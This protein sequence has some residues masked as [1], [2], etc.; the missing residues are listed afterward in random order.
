MESELVFHHLSEVDSTNN[1]AV[2]KV[3]E[4][5]AKNGMAWFADNQMQG[6]GQRNKEWISAPGE[7]IILSIVL[8]NLAGF[9][10][11]P[12]VFNAFI[13]NLCR[14]FV[15]QQ[16]GENVLIKWPNDLYVH[17]K[18]T[19]G[20][21]IENIYRGSSWNWSI[22]GIGINVNQIHFSENLPNPTS[23][24]KITNFKYDALELS[25]M[26]H[27]YVFESFSSMSEIDSDAI[28][29][30]YNNNLYKKNQRVRFRKN[31]MVFEAMVQ[32]VNHFGELIVFDTIQKSYR[33]GEI[34]WLL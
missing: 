20:I 29:K 1:Y 14:N 5:L 7:N 26:L 3:H 34:D 21:L 16:I 11:V 8:N 17:D 25:K 13:A 10:H 23:F 30:E 4:G 6:K 18:K 33:F 12:F 9:Q 15:S 2:A 31:N 24:K 32:S 22:I 28:I 19:G 27:L